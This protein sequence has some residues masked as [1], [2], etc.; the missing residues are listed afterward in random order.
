[1]TKRAIYRLVTIGILLLG[2]LGCGEKLDEEI[3]G[4]DGASMVLIPAG[5]FQMGRRIG[6]GD[7]K[8][9][10]SVYL[11]AFYIDRH[12]VTNGQYKKFV[13]ATGSEAPLLWRVD[14]AASPIIASTF[15][16]EARENYKHPDWPVLGISWY[17]AKAYCDWAGKRLPREAEWE[18]MARSGLTENIYASKNAALYIFEWCADWYGASYYAISPEK[19]PS[20]PDSGQYRIVRG[21]MLPKSNPM[22]RNVNARDRDNALPDSKGG[23]NIFRCVQDVNPNAVP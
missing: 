5:K 7:E 10:H 22:L 19:N 4:K 18:K 23:P 15:N 17:E 14:F 12:P 9:I 1:M 16:E 20:G 3:I 6:D 11:D 13:D 21:G 8:P 2:L